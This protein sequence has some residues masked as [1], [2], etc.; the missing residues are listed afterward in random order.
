MSYL[1]NKLFQLTLGFSV[2]F[3]FKLKLKVSTEDARRTHFYC[4]TELREENIIQKN[5][6][7]YCD[8]N[9]ETTSLPFQ[10]HFRPPNL[11]V[12]NPVSTFFQFFSKH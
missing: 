6:I 5:K 8:V 3:K 4:I 11:Y 1:D 9:N 10:H 7:K 12:N 2:K